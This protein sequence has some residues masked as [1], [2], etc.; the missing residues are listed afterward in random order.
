MNEKFSRETLSNIQSIYQYQSCSFL[1]G[2]GVITGTGGTGIIIHCLK[3]ISN[4][5]T[6]YLNKRFTTESVG[7]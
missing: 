5:Y 2:T 7:N 6:A 1:G 4:P 3:S